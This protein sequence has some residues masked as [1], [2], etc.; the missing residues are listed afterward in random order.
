MLF[1]DY[2]EYKNRYIASQKQYDEILQEKEELFA[3]T[4]PNAVRFDKEK[5]SGG[6]IENAFDDYLVKKERK[7]IDNRLQEAKTLLEDR[8]KLL[9]LKLEELKES[10]EILDKVYRLNK[11]EHIRP[12]K[13]ARIINY[14]VSQVYR[15]LEQ[16][17][18][19]IEKMR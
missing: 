12:Y 7:Q 15:F 13:I 10:N 8:K 17:D 2:E 9:A 18:R 11:V 3:R 1:I 4:Q 6:T 19:F 14:S 16:I 5:V